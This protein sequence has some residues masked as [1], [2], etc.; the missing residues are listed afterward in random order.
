MVTISS[1]YL[2]RPRTSG[3]PG[4]PSALKQRQVTHPLPST[5]PSQPTQS[6]EASSELVTVEGEDVA[7][8]TDLQEK[9]RQSQEARRKLKELQEVMA[10]LQGMVSL[11]FSFINP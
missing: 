5:A 6:L 4:P 7:A 11:P 3:K 8:M 1:T 2:T 10:L 9:M